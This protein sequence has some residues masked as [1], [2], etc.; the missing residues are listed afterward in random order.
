[1]SERAGEYVDSNRVLKNAYREGPDKEGY[2]AV[3]TLGSFVPE[4]YDAMSKLNASPTV[5]VYSYYNQGLGGQLVAVVTVTY[6]NS[7]KDDIVS[8]VRTSP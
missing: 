6:T 8:V 1:M 4:S 3:S 7:G 2:L 5:E